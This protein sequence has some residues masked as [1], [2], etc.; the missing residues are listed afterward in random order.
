MLRV[1][2]AAD[3]ILLWLYIV[4]FLPSHIKKGPCTMYTN[5]AFT[6]CDKYLVIAHS[7]KKIIFYQVH[8]FENDKL[9]LYCW[10]AFM[11]CTC[12]EFRHKFTLTFKCHFKCWTHLIQMAKPTITG[13]EGSIFRTNSQWRQCRHVSWVT[14]N[15]TVTLGFIH[16]KLQ[17]AAYKQSSFFSF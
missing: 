5:D 3:L 16:E 17:D 1:C 12:E 2:I 14:N 8:C 6:F 7:E 4:A 11:A 15:Q 10:Q 13:K 9:K